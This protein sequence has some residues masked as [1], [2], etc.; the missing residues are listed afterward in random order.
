[1][2][3]VHRHRRP[4]ARSVQPLRHHLLEHNPRLRT[5]ALNPLRLRSRRRTRLRLSLVHR[6]VL[7]REPPS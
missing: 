7:S 3:T 2:E 5:R 6:H 4:L 1:M